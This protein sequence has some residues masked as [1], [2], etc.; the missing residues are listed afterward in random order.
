M[1]VCNKCN[2]EKELKEFYK[3]SDSDNY[4]GSCKLCYNNTS[5]LYYKDFGSIKQVDRRKLNGTEKENEYARNRYKNNPKVKETKRKYMIKRLNSDN[6]FKLSHNIR[7]LIRN[8]FY[9]NGFSKNTKSHNILGCSFIE[10]KSF[11]E[12]KFEEGMSWDNYGKWHLDHIIPVSLASNE[13][14]ILKF[15]KYKNFQ[16]M[17][18][19]EN[20]KKSNKI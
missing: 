10:F 16:P 18:A 8:S 13:S 19:I 4:R 6:L 2:I 3:R 20:I 11:I 15:N 7:S 5:K 1:K 9:K 17:W 14:Q 12:S